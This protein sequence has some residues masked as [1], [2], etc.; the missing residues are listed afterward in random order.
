MA[1]NPRPYTFSLYRA[2]G[3]LLTGCYGNWSAAPLDGDVLNGE[4]ATLADALSAIDALSRK[5]SL[6]A[7]FIVWRHGKAVKGASRGT[8]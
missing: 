1:R 8:R 3:Q 6:A 4:A 5:V 2:D 7:D